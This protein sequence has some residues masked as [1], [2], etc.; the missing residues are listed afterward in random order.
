MTY[1]LVME[2]A[3]RVTERKAIL[4]DGEPITRVRAVNPEGQ[5]GL[6]HSIPKLAQELN[7]LDDDS[8]VK[9][10]IFENGYWVERKNE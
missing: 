5:G 10:T 9:I 2:A 4:G 7:G 1:L 8:K 6:K 3:P